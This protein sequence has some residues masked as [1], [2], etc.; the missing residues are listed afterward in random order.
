MVFMAPE[1]YCMCNPVPIDEAF[2]A[3]KPSKEDIE[4]MNASFEK[5]AF[6]GFPSELGKQHIWLESLSSLVADAIKALRQDKGYSLKTKNQSRALYKKIYYLKVLYKVLTKSAGDFT[7]NEYAR[8]YEFNVL[9]L[10]K[11]V[12]FK[13]SEKKFH[14]FLQKVNTLL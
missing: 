11:W 2:E 12:I 1:D 9:M 3:L 14:K 5:A 13:D 4:D 8:L 6:Q 7:Q 10:V